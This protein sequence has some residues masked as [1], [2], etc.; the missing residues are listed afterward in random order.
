M[1][2]MQLHSTTRCKWCV[3]LNGSNNQ[4]MHSLRMLPAHTVETVI[5]GS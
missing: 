3:L 2:S 5:A 4:E 1:L